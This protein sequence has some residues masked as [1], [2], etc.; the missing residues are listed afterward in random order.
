MLS[1][2]FPVAVVVM[3]DE[4]PWRCH[5]CNLKT[6]SGLLSPWSKGSSSPI[7]RTWNWQKNPVG[8]HR[9]LFLYSSA[10]QQTSKYFLHYIHLCKLLNQKLL[11]YKVLF[12]LIYI[13]NTSF[14]AHC[15]QAT[16]GLSTVKPYLNRVQF[17]SLKIHTLSYQWQA[18]WEI[19]LA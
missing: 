17:C 7:Q 9:I 15:P 3:T 1:K 8:V 18:L 14:I 11:S 5:F 12:F 6:L 10:F 2:N 19:L 16:P 4:G 13:W